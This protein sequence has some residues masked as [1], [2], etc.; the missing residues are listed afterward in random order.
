MDNT[1]VPLGD[2]VDNDRGTLKEIVVGAMSQIPRRKAGDL[3]KDEVNR[4]GGFA[5]E[6]L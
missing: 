5:A 4:H 1:E 6:E 3:L 2:Q